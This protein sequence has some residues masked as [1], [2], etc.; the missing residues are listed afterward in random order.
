MKIENL[1]ARLR[2]N[3]MNPFQ[4]SIKYS[5]R[6][7]AWSVVT[8]LDQLL[9]LFGLVF[10]VSIQVMYFQYTVYFSLCLLHERVYP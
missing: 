1:K 6:Q 3:F 5:S 8:I 10:V 4:K 9:A 7:W 2:W